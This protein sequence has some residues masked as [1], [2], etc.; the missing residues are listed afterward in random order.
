VLGLRAAEVEL[1]D[2]LERV[3][4]GVARAELVHDLGEDLADLVFEAVGVVGAFAEALEV[5]EEVAVDEVD[6]V[7][8]VRAAL[9][10]SLPSGVFGAAQVFQ[11]YSASMIGV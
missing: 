8:P 11:L 7:A 6:Q 9:W 3:A 10:S 4:E 2:D 1:V 5:G